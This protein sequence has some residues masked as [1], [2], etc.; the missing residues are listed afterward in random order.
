MNENRAFILFTLWLGGARVWLTAESRWGIEMCLLTRSGSQGA[1][2][3][4]GGGGGGG[5]GGGPG[6]KDHELHVIWG[7]SSVTVCFM[8]CSRRL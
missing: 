3:D 2:P 5:G 8:L 7:S 4:R 6:W 1:A